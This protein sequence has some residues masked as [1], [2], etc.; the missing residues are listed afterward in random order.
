MTRA[1]TPRIA[2]LRSFA[3]GTEAR[4]IAN[5]RNGLIAESLAVHMI[6]GRGRMIS[7]SALK[8][9][10][11]NDLLI[12]HSALAY[13][14]FYAAFA[15]MLGKPVVALVWDHYPVTIAGRRYDPSLRRRMLDR[16]E[17][18]ALA[19]CSDVIVPSRDFQEA[20]SLARATVVPFWLPVDTAVQPVALPRLPGDRPPRI[21][22]AD[23]SMPRAVWGR[24]MPRLTG[25]LAGASNWS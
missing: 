18:L 22:F 15:R 23:R 1:I 11:R 5:I 21:I 6:E 16:I 2:L 4:I 7:L 20:L 13:A 12:V 9:I 17:G 19:L 24:P 8:A 10:A 3:E 14:V 25:I